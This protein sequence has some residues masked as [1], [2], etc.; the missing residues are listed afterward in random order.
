MELKYHAAYFKEPDGWYIVELLD[1]PGVLSQG[2]TLKSARWMIRDALKLMAEAMVEDGESLPRPNSK[3]RAG[4]AA[5]ADFR[6]TI[7]LSTRFQT[8][9]IK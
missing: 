4:K 1:F 2:K 9:G 5:K 3:A 6:E 8:A 7:R